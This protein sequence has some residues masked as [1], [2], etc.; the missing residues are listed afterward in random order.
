[1]PYLC[2]TRTRQASQRCSNERVVF[3]ISLWI[4]MN[5]VP[6]NVVSS[7]QLFYRLTYYFLNNSNALSSS[8]ITRWYSLDSSSSHTHSL[9]LINLLFPFFP[10]SYK[11]IATKRKHKHLYLSLRPYLH[12]EI[13]ILYIFPI[14]ILQ[15]WKIL[16]TFAQNI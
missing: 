2:S 11:I 9:L 4:S 12:K 3:F 5:L 6:M 8:S 13:L 10:R 1:M 16:C 14:K 15:G 7:R